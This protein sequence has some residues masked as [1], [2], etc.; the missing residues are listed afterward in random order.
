MRIEGVEH[1]WEAYAD[2]G[3]PLCL[4]G[5]STKNHPEGISV[6]IYFTE[7]GRIEGVE[8]WDGDAEEFLAVVG[9]TPNREKEEA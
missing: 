6:S 9:D 4:A 2:E 8:V 3:A 5:K 1:V 7:E